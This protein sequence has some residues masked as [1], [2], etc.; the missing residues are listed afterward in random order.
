MKPGVIAA[1]VFVLLPAIVSGQI[2][3]GE[4]AGRVMDESGGVL[5]GATVTAT[6]QASGT[7]VTRLTDVE[8][9]FYLPALRVGTWDLTIVLAGFASEARKGLVLEIGAVL[10]LELT[11]A[12]E[13]R[14]EE[15]TVSAFAPLLQTST[16]ELSDVIENREV[17]QLPLN[18]RTFL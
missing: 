3:T 11:L 8:G 18:G 1:L 2:N 10:S 17:V 6:H 13:A 16:A 5:P 7:V 15:I 14:A 4:L 12:V 9:R